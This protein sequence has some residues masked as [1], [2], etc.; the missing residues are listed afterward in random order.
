MTSVREPCYALH[1]GR[2]IPMIELAPYQNDAYRW[3]ALHPFG[4]LADEPGVGKTHPAI[5]AAKS[6]TGRKLLVV[7]AYL[8][9]NWLYE[10]ERCDVPSSDIAALN[11]SAEKRRFLYNQ[12]REWSIMS[13]E[14][15]GKD[16]KEEKLIERKWQLV[17]FDEAHRLRGRDSE[18]TKSAF[19]M[20]KH[21][22]RMW[23]LTGTPLVSKDR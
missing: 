15:F 11:I 7:P 9:T 22:E 3:F 5:L 14:L 8:I 18:R 17:L 10:L 6:V 1:H 21:T 20:R 13:Y 19:Q 4:I 2:N 12:D 23:F 16:Y